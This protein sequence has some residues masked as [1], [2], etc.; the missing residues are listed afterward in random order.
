MS[1]LVPEKIMDDVKF[2]HFENTDQ[3]LA[4]AE[5]LINSK[6]VPPSLKTP[7]AVVAVI[8]QGRELGFGPVTSVNNINNIQGK[9]TLSIHAM[10]A[11]ISQAGIVYQVIKDFEDITAIKDGE[12][13]IVD[14]VTVIRFFKK[15]NGQIITNDISYHWSEAAK[16]GYTT[17]DNWQ[18]MP[19]IML[20]NRCLAIGAR[21]VCPE[22]ILGLYETAELADAK[23][24]NYETTEDGVVILD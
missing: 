18:K 16:S 15:W 23:G 12:E 8:L 7:E 3:A 14:R 24:V 10:T 1:E 13:K 2:S 17:K 6:L 4:F 11:K 22:A 9:P 20:R 19:R 21:F 5:V